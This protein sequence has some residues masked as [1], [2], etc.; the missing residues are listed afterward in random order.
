MFTPF[1]AT[2]A[3][4]GHV[5][6]ILTKNSEGIKKR[7]G[8]EASVLS[9]KI[10]SLINQYEVWDGDTKRTCTYGDIAILL[11]KRT[12]LGVFEDALR[13]EGIPFIILKGIGFYD[14]PE[15]ALLRE[16][17]SFIINPADDYSL[18]CFLRSPVFGIDY[19]ILHELI[20]KDNIPLIDK[21][22]KPKNKKV[23]GA[24]NIISGW[25]DKSKYTPLAMLLEDTLSETE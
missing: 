7:R 18:F 22:Q 21:M 16:L 3:G 6:L 8:Q 4:N 14:E 19:R 2:R 23:K 20:C 25:V 12:H 17:I 9:K 13:R 24:F 5:E 10:Q 15:V 11:R 1:E